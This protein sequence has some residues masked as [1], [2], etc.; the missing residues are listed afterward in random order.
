MH[1]LLPYITFYIICWQNINWR[2][3][4]RSVILRPPLKRISILNELLKHRYTCSQSFP[5]VY[6]CESYM[7]KLVFTLHVLFLKTEVRR[8]TLFVR[9]NNVI[10]FL[11]CILKTYSRN[12]ISNE[13][14]KL[15]HLINWLVKDVF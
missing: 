8:F 5:C 13:L 11:Q 10:F 7:Q 6:T 2:R 9:T 3:R 14:R 1:K 15:V 4:R 12:W